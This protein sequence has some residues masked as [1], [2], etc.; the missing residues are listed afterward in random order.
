MTGKS[1]IKHGFGKSLSVTSTK[2]LR[3][4]HWLD[5]HVDQLTYSHFDTITIDDLITADL[6]RYSNVW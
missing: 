3:K 5:V 4:I 1:L 2:R 6:S